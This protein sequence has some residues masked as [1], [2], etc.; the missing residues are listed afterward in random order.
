MPVF[1]TKTIAQ[2]LEPVAEQVSSLVILHEQGEDGAAMP[3]LEKPIATVKDAVANLASVGNQQAQSTNDN[4]LKLDTPPAVKKVEAAADLLTEAAK[5]LAANEYSKPGREKLIAGARG[6]LQGTSDLLLVFD[7]AE[8]RRICHICQSVREYLKVSKVVNRMEDLIT[9]VKS[10]TPGMTNM[11]KLVVKRSEDLTNSVHAQILVNKVNN[12]KMWLPNLISSLKAYI[13]TVDKNDENIQKSADENREFYVINMSEEITEIIHLILNVS[14]DKYSALEKSNLGQLKELHDSIKKNAP[15]VDQWLNKPL[16]K[17]NSKDETTFYKE[18]CDIRKVGDEIGGATGENIYKKNEKLINMVENLKELEKK[19]ET[20]TSEAIALKKQA[21]ESFK[22]LLLDVDTAFNQLNTINAAKNIIASKTPLAKEWLVD[23]SSKPTPDGECSVIKDIID[24]T[25]VI[26]AELSK[27]SIT[28]ENCSEIKNLLEEVEKTTQNAIKYRANDEGHLPEAREASKVALDKV[29]LLNE[30]IAMILNKPLA[31][32]SI[33]SKV[34]DINKWLDD[35]EANDGGQG[36]LAAGSLISTARELAANIKNSD[37][38]R[39]E[40]LNKAIECEKLSQDL[41]ELQR[42]GKGDSD[43]AQKLSQTLKIKFS[44][45]EELINDGLAEAVADEFSDALVNLEQLTFIAK[46]EKSVPNR[47]ENFE[48]T[49]LALKQQAY[50]LATIAQQ[51]VQANELSNEEKI[52]YVTNSSDKLINLTPQVVNAGKV[53]LKSP[54]NK[55]AQEHLKAL[56]DEWTKTVDDL[57]EQVDDAVDVIKFVQATQ[58]AIEQENDKCTAA[59]LEEKPAVAL[60]SSN[61]IACQ[62]NRIVNA[63]K[64]E[65]ENIDEPAYVDDINECLVNINSSFTPMLAA[66]QEFAEKPASKAAQDKVQSN[67][68]DLIQSVNK[69]CETIKE[70]HEKEKIVPVQIEQK[71]DAKVSPQLPLSIDEELPP[72]PPLPAE[73]ELPTRPPLPEDEEFPEDDEYD[74]HE[75]MQA[76]RELH[77]ETIK[78][79]SSGNDIISAAKQMALLMAKMSQ[80]VRQEDGKKSDLISCAKDIAKASKEVTQLSLEIAE[81]CS[82]KRIRNDMK[83]TLD[84]IPTISTQLR[85]LSTV[86]AAS[87]GDKEDMTKE[88]EEAAEQAT[89]MLVHNAQNLMMSVKDTVRYAE[90]AS[91]RIRSDATGRIQWIRK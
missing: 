38:L 48:E 59:L 32:K 24:A 37:Q 4:V 67:N 19:G 41:N 27:D 82:D 6:I 21:K 62:A 77:E 91:I 80:L 83:R 73:E 70:K 15:L 65:V 76:A 79:N 54:E 44:E 42:S 34:D 87:L 16:L 47:E 3:P 7:E 53:V 81:K 84:R 68:K 26:I 46:S 40:I 11:C 49:S 56:S 86:K 43:E 89:E 58:K 88:E 1:H 9:F 50:K 57:T 33:Q 18:I 75:M 61:K 35:P 29:M 55:Q 31:A 60:S 52:G 63:G 78:W 14:T 5:L 71:N 69:L 28:A 8:V 12:L 2:I 66:T 22:D 39:N 72:R 85:I 74:D 20:E 64:H 90:A 36:I 51:T 23:P 25:K 45:L 13:T 10:L 30:K 17:E